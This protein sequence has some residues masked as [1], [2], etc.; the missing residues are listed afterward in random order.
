MPADDISRIESVLTITGGQ[1]VYAA[2]EYE[3]LAVPVPPVEPACAAGVIFFRIGA[4]DGSV[5][6]NEAH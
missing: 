2:A 1:I 5:G 4:N 6:S 3:G